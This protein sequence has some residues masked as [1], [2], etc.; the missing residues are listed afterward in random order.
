MIK[1]PTQS[2]TLLC[3][4]GLFQE[5]CLSIEWDQQSCLLLLWSPFY[6]GYFG[7]KVL[8]LSR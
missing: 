1:S 4:Q 2:P 5:W 7:H 6:S 3:A 8:L